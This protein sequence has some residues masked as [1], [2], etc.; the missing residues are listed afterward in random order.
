MAK[1]KVSASDLLY[2]L[3]NGNGM[4]AWFLD[5]QTGEFL[6]VGDEMFRDE[7]DDE[8]IERIDS[9]PGRYVGVEPIPSYE[10]FKTMERFLNEVPDDGDRDRLAS[11]LS[12][13][14]PFRRFKDAL[15]DMG[16][17]RDKW[18]EFHDKEMLRLALQWLEDEQIDAEL[19][20]GMPEQHGG[21]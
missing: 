20:S 1:I 5:K 11:A 2:A 21:A 8:L 10:S 13:R 7:L 6:H 17:L 15:A 16:D 14:K 4:P 3:E 19:V 9:K 12:Q 18:F